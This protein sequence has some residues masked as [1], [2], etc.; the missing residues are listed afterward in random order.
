[1]LPVNIAVCLKS[2]DTSS[3]DIYGCIHF[4]GGETEAQRSSNEDRIEICG[5]KQ[6]KHTFWSSLS[7]SE[8]PDRS[9]LV[10]LKKLFC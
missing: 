8:P 9:R 6:I 1:M 3:R 2:F 4:I 10:I 5:Q 7:F